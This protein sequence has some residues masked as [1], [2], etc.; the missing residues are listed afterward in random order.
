MNR[1]LE[2]ERA[3]L[4][5]ACEDSFGLYEV[6]WT[7]NTSM[8]DVD[9]IERRRLARDA[10]KSLV[11]RGLV[12]VLRRGSDGV[13]LPVQPEHA[14]STVSSEDAWRV[15]AY[16][17]EEILLFRTDAGLKLWLRTDRSN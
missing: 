10:V 6:D 11:L 13:E 1:R 2:A 5:G 12:E 9:P 8:P 16:G 7:L 17:R 4:D 14:L 3:A 15:P